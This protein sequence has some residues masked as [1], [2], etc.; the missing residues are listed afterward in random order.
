MSMNNIK[1][2]KLMNG[3][4]VAADVQYSG[5][6]TYTLH[7]AVFWD[8]VRL[9]DEKYDVQFFPL[10]NGAKMAP[11]ATHFALTVNIQKSAIL[12]E[13]ELRNEVEAKYRQ[14]ISPIL[15]INK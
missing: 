15:L 14:L 2:L 8:L 10:T 9:Q 3:A 11:D 1:G 4:E 5:D 7:N 12:F 6:S 13:Y